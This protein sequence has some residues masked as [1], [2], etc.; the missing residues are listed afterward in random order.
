MLDANIVTHTP[1]FVLEYDAFQRNLELI[2]EL[3]Q[4][5]P[6]TFLFA[7]KGFGMHRVFPEI[8]TCAQ[9]ATASSLYEAHLASKFFPTVHAYAPVYQKD[10]F[11]AIAKLSSHITF[12]SV[13]QYTRYKDRLGSSLAGLRVNPKYEV[14]ETKLYDPCSPGSRLG[15]NP[16]N[17]EELPLGITGLHVHNLCESGAAEMK[18]TLDAVEK[19]YGRFF[20]SLTWLN[21]GGGHLVTRE[22]YDL[23]LFKDTVLSFN[24]RYPH[25]ELIFEPGAAYV[26]DTGVLVSEILDIV[27]SDGI[28]TLMLDTSFTAHMPDCLEMPYTPKV[29]GATI[30]PEQSG[31]EVG[32]RVRLGGDSCLAGD[33]VGTYL[34]PT[35]PKIG[36]RLIFA[37]MMHYTMVKTTMFNGIALP[38]IGIARDGRYEVVKHFNYEDYTNRLS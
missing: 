38:D 22:G 14:V 34:F 30:V 37:D 28:T 1:A 4:E 7:L 32:Y 2:R 21:L 33:W 6:C 5:L 3:Q 12:N 23:K 36:D 16:A 11:D 25:I 31:R 24:R 17:L 29:W 15:V 8:A 20:S 18:G 13:D 9:G 27:T 35:L 10:E 26:W 19:Q